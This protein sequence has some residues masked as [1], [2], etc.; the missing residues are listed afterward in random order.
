MKLKKMHYLFLMF[1]L[2]SFGGVC[3]AQYGQSQFHNAAINV[4]G[5]FL[6][7]LDQGNLQG[8]LSV[9]APMLLYDYSYHLGNLKQIKSSLRGSGTDRIYLGFEMV[10]GGVILRFKSLY[11]VGIIFESITVTADASGQPF[12]MGWYFQPGY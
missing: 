9:V 5:I 6:S 12:V 3:H 7:N 11:P 1:C 8:S 2:I 4:A 10:P